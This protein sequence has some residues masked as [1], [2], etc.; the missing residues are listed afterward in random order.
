MPTDP[1]TLLDLDSYFFEKILGQFLLGAARIRMIVFINSNNIVK[2]EDVKG[3]WCHVD[4]N[5]CHQM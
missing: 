1:H 3:I 4:G 2:A 5:N